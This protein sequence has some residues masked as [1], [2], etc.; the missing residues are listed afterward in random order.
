M[1]SALYVLAVAGSFLSHES[2]GGVLLD[3]SPS[4]IYHLLGQLDICVVTSVHLEKET[5]EVV[6][7]THGPLHLK[8]PRWNENTY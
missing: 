3:N 4:P 8:L 5:V 6:E 1:L 2:L 7:L